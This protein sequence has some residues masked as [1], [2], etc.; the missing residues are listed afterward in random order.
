MN[1]HASENLPSQ[2]LEPT[3]PCPNCGNAMVRRTV[4]RGANQGD[5][6]WGCP[7]FPKCRGR[8]FD[9]LT[10]SSGDTTS[11]HLIPP[12]AQEESVP[13]DVSKQGWKEKLGSAIGGMVA[14][15]D[16]IQRWHLESN[17]PD[18]KGHWDKDQRRKV[19]K[20][21][22]NRDGGRC[23][24]CAGDMKN[25]KGAQIEHIVPKVFAVFDIQDRGKAVEGTHYKSLLHKLDNLQVAHSYCN[26]R[27]GNTPEMGKWRHPSM[28][29]LGVAVKIG[30]D[31]KLTLPGQ[32][33]QDRR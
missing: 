6:F 8:I 11:N 22:Y 3:P 19:L 29:P 21:I 15:V 17:E 31:K 1:N 5:I 27:K 25:T 2:P 28:P 33:L 24:L 16:K 26:K 10:S 12:A 30:A 20:Y 18:A 9:T 13:V 23:G 4:A 7:K 32:L 14:G